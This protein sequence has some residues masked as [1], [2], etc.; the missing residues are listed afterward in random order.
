MWGKRIVG[1][2]REGE[3]PLV[4]DRNLRSILILSVDRQRADCFAI[5][6]G[7]HGVWTACVDLKSPRAQS[8]A[9]VVEAFLAK[10]FIG[11]HNTGLK[12]SRK[13]IPR[14]GPVACARGLHCNSCGLRTFIG[15]NFCNK[16]VVDL[17]FYGAGYRCVAI[18]YLDREIRWAPDYISRSINSD[19]ACRWDNSNV[20]LC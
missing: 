1:W 7:C 17:K 8:T 15:Q 18:L 4:I 10:D 16:T 2:D 20:R 11:V 6:S 3:L 13:R 12:R 5:K 9:Y 14:V 19:H